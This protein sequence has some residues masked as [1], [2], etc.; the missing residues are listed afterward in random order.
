MQH[1]ETFKCDLSWQVQHLVKFK[2]DFSWQGYYLLKISYY[3]LWQVQNLMI[4]KHYFSR[5]VQHWVTFKLYFSWQVTWVWNIVFFN[6]KYLWWIRKVTWIA[7]WVVDWRFYARIKLGLLSDCPRI[8]NPGERA[9]ILINIAKQI[10]I[11]IVF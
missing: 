1:L 11:S 3:F 9:L 5:Q 8:L 2:F 6:T 4:F 10:L 7:R